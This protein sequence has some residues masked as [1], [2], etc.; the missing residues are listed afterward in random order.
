MFF[1][2]V[3]VA[4]LWGGRPERFG[5]TAMLLAWAVFRNAHVM[6]LV[7]D[8]YID[9]TVEDT[10]M[11]LAFGWLA[12]RS[13]RWWPLVATAASALTVLVH[14]LSMATDISWDAA[15]SARVGLGLLTCA[16]LLA[17]VAERWLAG[18]K[19]ISAIRQWR[20]RP[21]SGQLEG[22]ATSRSLS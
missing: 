20:R 14:I 3:V 13:N 4:W 7:G 9:S 18:E 11:L 1:A 5:A 22:T 17:G 15:V 6:W 12:V 8:V 2:A 16:T 10:L 21:Q 19:A